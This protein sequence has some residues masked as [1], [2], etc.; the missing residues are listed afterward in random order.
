MTTSRGHTLVELIVVVAI[1]AVLT[2]VAVPRLRFDAVRQARGQ[3][4]AQSIATD[5]RLARSQAILR[6]I[7]SPAGCALN[8]TG[9]QPYDGYEIVDL[10]DLSVIASHDL[11]AGVQCTGGTQF[12]F[13]PLGGL[14]EGS[15]THL[16]VTAEGR[17]TT[18]TVLPATGMVRCL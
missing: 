3:I 14:K 13:S 15:D 9:S 2:A 10:G 18:I 8:M 4:A 11:P 6:A 7:N 16:N 17:T 1:L 5:L 12:Q